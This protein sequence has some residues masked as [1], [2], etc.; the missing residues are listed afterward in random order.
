[1]RGAALY[2]TR[3]KKRLA[4][5]R[6]EVHTTTAMHSRHQL[7]PQQ[8][9]KSR[10]EAKYTNTWLVVPVVGESDRAQLP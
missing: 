2:G 4:T 8:R 7:R 3:G 9:N 1:M 10:G 6:K 5:A